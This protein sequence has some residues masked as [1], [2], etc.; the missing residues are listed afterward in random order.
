MQKHTQTAETRKK[1]CAW[2]GAFENWTIFNLILYT[3]DIIEYLNFDFKM[4]Q[5][6]GQ[7]LQFPQFSYV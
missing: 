2:V 1:S 4:M 6:N 7:N 3:I 5:N